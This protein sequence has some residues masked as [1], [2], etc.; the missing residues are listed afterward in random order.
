MSSVLT[1]SSRFAGRSGEDELVHAAAVEGDR[2]VPAGLALAQPRQQ[3]VGVQHRGLGCLLEAVAAEAEDVG[4]GAHEDAEVALEA[5][6][7]AD[8][9]GPLEVEVEAGLAAVLGLAAHHLRPRQE[10]LDPVRAGDRPRTG[11][12]A[13]VRL[14]EGLVQVDVD[15]VEA[16]VAGARVAHDRVQVGAVVVEGPARVVDDLGD[17]RDV[18]VEEPEGVRVGQHQAGRVVARLRAQVVEVDAAALVGGQLHHLVAG[19]RHRGGVGAVGRVGGEH[20]G[21]LLAAVG[22]VGAGEQQPRQLAVG[23]RRGLEADVRAGR[24][25][26]PGTAAAAT[27][28]RGRP[29][30]ASAPG[31][32]A[33]G[34]G[35]AAPPPAR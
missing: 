34:R 24:R 8:R 2:Y 23:A 28:A 20:L 19:H 9:L 17:L 26:R 30:R 18:L 1:P 25:S 12:A 3:V 33:G 16:H 11:A 5:A 7:P 14:R 27:S 15:D 31:P 13:A 32:G 29:A 10:G 22:V 35:P 4:V 6:Q 21:P